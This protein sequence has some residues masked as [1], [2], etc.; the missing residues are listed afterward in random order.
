MAR[1]DNLKNFLFDI[2]EKLREKLKTT[3]AIVHA[4]YDT[5]IDEVFD[6]GYEKARYDYTNFGGDWRYAFYCDTRKC[7]R[8]NLRAEDGRKVVDAR[9]MVY[10]SRGLYKLPSVFTLPSVEIMDYAFRGCTSLIEAP[11]ISSPYLRSL[12]YGFCEC[13]SLEKVVINLEGVTNEAGFKYAFTDCSALKHLTVLGKI[14]AS[15]LKLAT[16]REL[17]VESLMSVINALYDYSE[18]GNVCTLTLGTTNLNKL[19]DEQIAVAVE[20]GWTLV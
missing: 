3:D 4:E 20:K 5:K 11:V 16:S 17:T 7:I 2:A 1:V 8:D 9:Y 13:S 10:G 19:T 18:S 6:A 12:A 15:G 14:K